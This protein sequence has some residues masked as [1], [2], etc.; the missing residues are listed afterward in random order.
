MSSSQVRS[1]LLYPV[2][3]MYTLHFKSHNVNCNHPNCIQ[4]SVALLSP[5][6]P[7]SRIANPDNGLT[8][9][10][11]FISTRPCAWGEQKKNINPEQLLLSTRHAAHRKRA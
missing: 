1:P 7:D 6:K 11:D 9:Y 3:I 4:L 5:I 2:P 8:F 10:L